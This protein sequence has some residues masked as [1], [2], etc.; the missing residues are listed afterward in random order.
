MDMATG[1][2][3]AMGT[4]MA[5][6]TVTGMATATTKTKVPASPRLGGDGYCLNESQ[7][8]GNPSNFL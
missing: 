5:T 3:M 2:D 6:G 1:T 8:R 7:P 4:D